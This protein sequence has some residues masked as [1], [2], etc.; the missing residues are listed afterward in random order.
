[1]SEYFI[2]GYSVSDLHVYRIILHR[3]DFAIGYSWITMAG[4]DLDFVTMEPL[5]SLHIQL[6]PQWFFGS[7]LLVAVAL[8][9]ILDEYNFIL[10]DIHL[11]ILYSADYSM[12]CR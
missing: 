6:H 2:G 12:D 7:F 5:L 8:S 3:Y 9:G 4:E 1:M 10:T 11:Y